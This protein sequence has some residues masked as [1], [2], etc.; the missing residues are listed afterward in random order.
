MLDFRKLFL[1]VVALALFASMAFGQVVAFEPPL[2]CTAQAAGTPSIRDNGV[3]E[4]VGDVLI[5]C[6]GGRPRPSTEVLPQ[7]NIQ[8]FTSPVIN[9]TSRI[10]GTTGANWTEA[11]L[12]VDEPQPAQQTICGSA[13]YPEA[14]PPGSP[15]IQTIGICGAHV[16]TG[17]GVVGPGG[18]LYGS[19]IGA[20]N[21]D[22]PTT[23]PSPTFAP[24][25]FPLGTNN[26]A[27]GAGCFNTYRGNTYQA[28]QAG[29][30]SLIWQGVP[31]D[32]PGTNTTRVFRITNVRVN[33][34]Q[35]NNPRGN[36]SSVLLIVSTNASGVANPIAMPITNPS[37]TV[38]I[39]QTPMD[40]SIGDGVDTFLQCESQNYTSGDPFAT[41][42][43]SEPL[44]NLVSG[45]QNSQFYL[46]YNER[47][48]TVFRRRSN[49]SPAAGSDDTPVVSG[50]A[51]ANSDQ[52]GLPYQTES[53][54][55]KAAPQNA[56]R[57]PLSGTSASSRGSLSNESNGAGIAS[58]GTRVIARFAN[59][60][61]G[62]RFF[63]GASVHLRA[64]DSAGSGVFTGWARAVV[65]DANG[66]APFAK[67][68]VVAPWP[69]SL[70][71]NSGSAA[72]MAPTAGN[73]FVEI[74]PVGNAG[75][76]AWEVLQTD[77]TAFEDIRI[78]MIVAY[79]S[80]TSSNLPTLGTATGSGHLAPL[81][82]TATASSSAPIPRFVEDPANNNKN[83][84]TI[85]AC[86]TNLLFPFVTNQGPF[87]TGLAISNTSKDPFGTSLQTGLCTVN[88]YGY[89]GANKVCLAYPSPSI[90]GGEHF[91]WSL[92]SGG[93]VTATAGFQGYV[94][95]QCAFQ[96]GHGYAFISDL[97]AQRLA[98]G[99]L[100]LIM[101]ESVGT[102]TGSKSE[103]LG[104]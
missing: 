81:S 80:N 102:R 53:G 92:S 26:C 17:L 91:A 51:A 28:R 88:F 4:L 18:G 22:D 12:F 100:A 7:V 30:N 9:I 74:V 58:H 83:M 29:N 15:Q 46:R 103:T 36:Q 6:S 5:I 73:G 71:L 24:T 54:H 27:V 43:A 90:T 86:V 42:P 96:Y 32:P 61:Q 87:D 77:T 40:F 16:G 50:N 39:A 97:G 67:A 10:T 31:I 33:A 64:V 69:G 37:P 60:P 21:P 57:W 38:A 3:T 20:Y 25:T 82:T 59:L 34:S 84:F 70:N 99:Y 14:V 98:Q 75:S 72:Y 41:T 48:P 44:Q 94:I 8:V 93:A 101:D 66:S 68:N 19:G 76:Q 62:A 49:A 35:L 55:Y 85:N 13:A 45:K 104:H 95:A 23:N 56:T 65:T 89:I 2:S 52:L 11:L 47:F 1:T 79:Q 63:A 78:P